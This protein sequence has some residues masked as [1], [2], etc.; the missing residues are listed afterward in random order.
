MKG[1]LLS[2]YVLLLGA[3]IASCACQKERGYTG[4]VDPDS[5]TRDI[6]LSVST[7]KACYAPG[8][9]IRFTATAN[10]VGSGAHIRCLHLGKVIHDELLTSAEWT[11]TAPSEDFRGYMA[12]IYQ[13]TAKGDL[14]L[15]T[16]GIDVSSDWSAFPRYGF[17]SKYGEMSEAACKA[18][19]SNLNRYHI[20]GVQFQ[21]WHWKHHWPLGG[22]REEPLA[23]YKDIAS[24]TTSLATLKNYISS[25]HSYGMKAIFYNLCYGA[26]DDALQDGVGEKWY[27]FR[28]TAHGNKDLHALS[29]P[30]KSSIY[31]VNPGNVQWQEY[32][33]AKTDDVYAVLDFD[34]YQID[35]L[36]YRGKRYDYDGAAVDLPEGYA[37]FIRAMKGRQPSKDLIM[38]AV[39]G[40]GAG[41]ILGTGDMC[42]AY[43]EMWANEPNFTDLRTHIENNDKYSAGKCKTVFAAYMNYRK[44]SAG[45]T[46]NT[47]GVLLTNAVMFALGGSHLEL[48]EHMLC[49]EY[50]PNSSLGM[51]A[52]L[53]Q[54]LV[55]YY[56]FLTAYENLLRD[57]G[58]LND[59]SVASSDNKLSF[60]SWGPETGKVVT[61]GRKVGKRQVVHL[62]NFLNA[63]SLSW[64][65]LEGTMPEPETVENAGVRIAVDGA[66][67]DVWT[68]SPDIDGGACR[69]VEY[70][71]DGS[72]VSLTLPSLKYWDMI[73]I[74][75][76]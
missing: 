67:A 51:S 73:V 28:D 53:K 68:A 75:Y 46:F 7:D 39:S 34:G 15:A 17:L 50:F 76:E 2:I 16:V 3:V 27:I 18:V 21:D 66:V 32:I 44:A 35:Q 33:G 69:R 43:D 55:S 36:G 10:P 63:D 14:V 37:S 52:D 24:R 12:E 11:W 61:L 71:S 70:S 48:G 64:R 23:T 31:L 13:T 58:E 29:A 40:Y 38:N 49:N 26:L 45:G 25:I 56:D 59:V 74:E 60:K 5:I 41:E 8:E 62:L 65:D 57:G 1:H 4:F 72:T 42:F 19:I 22:T 54:V 6:T 30:F 20:N 47:P 9:T